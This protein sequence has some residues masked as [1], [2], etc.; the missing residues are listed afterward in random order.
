MSMFIKSGTDIQSLYTSPRFN[1]KCSLWYFPL[2]S[3]YCQSTQTTY[4]TVHL[5]LDDTLIDSL[6]LISYIVIIILFISLS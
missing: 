1:D 2:C 5:H 4:A 6:T 3:I